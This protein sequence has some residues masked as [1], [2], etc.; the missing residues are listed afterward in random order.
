MT[1]TALTKLHHLAVLAVKR[2]ICA[3]LTARTEVNA[4]TAVGSVSAI[5]ATTVRHVHTKMSLRSIVY[6]GS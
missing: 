2:E 3:M 6:G 1:L 5:T 4:T